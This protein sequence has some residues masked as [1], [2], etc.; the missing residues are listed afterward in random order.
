MHFTVTGSSPHARVLVL[1][2]LCLILSCHKSP[3]EQLGDKGAGV[4]KVETGNSNSNQST[5]EEA[6]ANAPLPASPPKSASPRPSATRNPRA[7]EP[8]VYAKRLEPVPDAQVRRP[9]SAPPWDRDLASELDRLAYVGDRA[10]VRRLSSASSS[11]PVAL[12]GQASQLIRMS[13]MPAASKADVSDSDSRAMN[14]QLAVTLAQKGIELL[15][16][17]PEP[18]ET[19]AKE[20]YTSTLL[21]GLSVK[22]EALGLL[23]AKVD[24]AQVSSAET[25]Y[26]EYLAA[27]TDDD[28]RVSAEHKLAS[29]LYQVRELDKAKT[30]YESLLARD[31]ND[32][33]ALLALA[34][35]HRQIAEAQKAAGKD[36]E[37]A[38][39]SQRATSYSERFSNLASERAVPPNTV[40]A[41]VGAKAASKPREYAEPASPRPRPET[42]EQNK[43]RKRP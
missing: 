31:A 9:A 35:I 25:A 5:Q 40:K 6:A 8:Q 16:Q 12:I 42:M 11:D 39:S 2:S 24:R 19:A 34:R 26:R 1:A 28:K 43:A 21:R 37:A 38:A 3:P 4:A 20:K 15:K 32:R 41:P 13:P 14:Y 18:S 33:E 22:A 30:A 17:Q 7:T 29:M 36:T 10:I 23:A 27:E